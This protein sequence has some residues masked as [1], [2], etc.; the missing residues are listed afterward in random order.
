MNISDIQSYQA[1]IEAALSEKRVKDALI[2]L[3]DLTKSYHGGNLIDE[4]YNLEFTYKSMLKYTVEG[5]SDP[6]QQ[7]VYNNILVSCYHLS[8]QLFSEILENKSSA[9]FYETR[10]TLK[11]QN[12]NLIDSLEHFM[13]EMKKNEIGKEA[14]I[15]ITSQK[16]IIENVFNSLWVLK[17]FNENEIEL[18]KQLLNSNSIHYSY[19]SIFVSAITIGCLKEFDVQKLSI[20]FDILDQTNDKVLQ[21]TLTG[22]LLILYKY[23]NRIKLYSGLLSRLSLLQENEKIKSN[24]LIICI[25][26][27][28]TRETEKISQKLMDE[29]IP[30][31]VKMQPNLRNKLDLENMISEKFNEGENPEWEDFF[32]DSPELMSKLEELTELQMEG[33]DVFLNTFKMLKH[34]PFFNT[35]YNWLLPFY[36]ENE[37]LN[38]ELKNEENIFSSKSII[39]SLANSGFLCNS[40]KYSLFLSIPHMPK[41][42]KDMMGNMFQQQMEQMDEIEKDE[43]LIDGSKKNSIISNR[44]IQD[45]YRFYKLHPQH[46]QF[47]DVFSWNMDFHNKWFFTHFIAEE[48][49]LR[50]IA[51]FFFKKSY[52]NEAREAFLVMAKK[53]CDNIEILQKVGYCYQQQKQHKKALQYYL[54]ADILKPEQTWTTK[55]IALMYK[56]LKQA[57][58]ALEYYQLAERLKPEDLHTQASIGHCLL[59]LKD[60]NAALKYYFKVEY[61]DQSNTKVWRPIAW[62]SLVTGKFDQA[63]KYY[64]KLLVSSSGAHDLINL[65]HVYWCK[66]NRK[67]A[68]NCYQKAISQLNNNTNEFFETF[69]ED[70]N[71]LI[72]NGVEEQ[73]IPIMLDQLQYL[74]EE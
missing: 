37:E 42:Q 19:Q 62:C 43:S 70:K 18:I 60:Y 64:Q 20:L 29:I 67:E 22:L 36:L 17:N 38:A 74:L 3:G 12:I 2:I 33:S 63:E 15:Q 54:K 57:N 46:S 40:D 48:E 23:D 49:E 68:L 59:D 50:Q 16:E 7:K 51:E 21:R 6:E 27:I 24:L 32:K 1:K 55:K 25:Q 71:V 58:K 8:D 13:A 39:E 65:G 73:N 5:V 56:Y 61:L 14:G 34:F 69:N 45:L 10:R 72:K 28:R 47:E 35:M 4:H 44:Y 9:A 26:L 41:F 53:E 66:N 31:V 30:E 11:T 52:F